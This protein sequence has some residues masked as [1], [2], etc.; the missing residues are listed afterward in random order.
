MWMGTKNGL[1][2]VKSAYHL[3]KTLTKREAV[4]PS[5]KTRLH[6]VWKRI[7]NLKATNGVKM[8][9]WRACREVLPPRLNLTK[10]KLLKTIHALSANY[11]QDL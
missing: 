5:Y 7:W 8:F 2:T 9:M 4:E 3:H 11:I 10:K 6:E 1:F